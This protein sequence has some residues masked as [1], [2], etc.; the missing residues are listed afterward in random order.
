M[1]IKPIRWSFSSLKQFEN[2]ARAYY[3]TR[4]TKR[5]KSKK[6]D[7]IIYGEQAH[8]AAEDHV[9]AE[10]KQQLDQR[11]R[12]LA[13]VLTALMNKPGDKYPE[14]EMAVTEQL[15]RCDWDSETAWVRGIADLLIV[16]DH[17]AWCVDYKTG[18]SR[19]ADTDQLELMALM[20]FIH[21]PT[22]EKVFGALLF[23]NENKPVFHTLKRDAATARWWAFRERLARL[24]AASMTNVWHPKKSG[25]C[26]GC[27]VTTCEHNPNH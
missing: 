23:V 12:H 15:V 8:K 16:D 25:L 11:F 6:T 17:R 9:K 1:D 4:V 7:K 5:F 3:E 24:E 13:P 21:F 27:P 14:Y 26:K 20:T 10:G 2:C 22:V 18:K 19:Y